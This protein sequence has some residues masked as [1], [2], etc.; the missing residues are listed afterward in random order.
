MPIVTFAGSLQTNTILV[1]N[2]FKET[3]MMQLLINAMSEYYLHR[4]ILVTAS[5]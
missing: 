5:K 1:S 3:P 2:N 4:G